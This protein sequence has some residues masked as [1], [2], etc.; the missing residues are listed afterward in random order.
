MNHNLNSTAPTDVWN[1]TI[2][3]SNSDVYKLNLILQNMSYMYLPT[4][5]MYKN[6]SSRDRAFSRH[7]YLQPIAGKNNNYIF[8]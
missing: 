6:N 3:S 7:I 2:I 5:D 4:S 8:I 1:L